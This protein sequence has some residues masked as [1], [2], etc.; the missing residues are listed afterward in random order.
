VRIPLADLRMIELRKR[1]G[2]NLPHLLNAC[3]PSK[4]ELVIKVHDPASLAKLPAGEHGPGRLRVHPADVDATQ[5]M[6]DSILR[7]PLL[8]VGAQRPNVP[9][10]SIYGIRRE[11]VSLALGFLLTAAASLVSTV[12]MAIVIIRA[13]NQ[14]GNADA[15]RL[16]VIAA[17]LFVLACI[18][19]VVAGALQML[20][21]RSYRLCLAAALMAVL[22]WSPAWPLGL[23]V[24]IWAVVVLGRRDVM[25]AFLGEGDGLPPA[26]LED[27]EPRGRV[28]GKLRSLWRSF[29]GCF[30]T[31]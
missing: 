30:V 16:V 7:S 23:A 6:V 14:T 8:G 29:A 11:L 13:F 26:A 28:A 31:G 3:I 15:K 20:R 24:G 5:Q 27:S 2:S 12:A 4:P 18:G 25:L 9:F 19:L 10:A 17:S 21:L 22:P 1:P